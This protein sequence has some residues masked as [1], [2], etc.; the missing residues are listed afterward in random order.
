MTMTNVLASLAVHDLSAASAWYERLLG[1]GSRPMAEVIEWQL[2]SGGGLQVY[3]LP[4]RAGTGSCTFIVSD[5]DEIAQK[6]RS[7]GLAADAEP[8]HNDLVD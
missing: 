8:A 3:E 1:P 6:L 4:E 5:I 2:P 7:S